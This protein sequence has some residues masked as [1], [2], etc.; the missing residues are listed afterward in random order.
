MCSFGLGW[1]QQLP[2][3]LEHHSESQLLMTAIWG[4]VFALVYLW[5]RLSTRRLDS[6]RSCPKSLDAGFHQ[7]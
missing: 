1:A 6:G 3:F 2:G 7:S 5:R 4:I